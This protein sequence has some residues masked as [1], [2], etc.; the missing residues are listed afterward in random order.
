M[1]RFMRLPLITLLSGVAIAQGVAANDTV[2]V[3]TQSSII[4]SQ[5]IDRQTASAFNALSAGDLQTARQLLAPLVKDYPDYHL[6]QLLY[7]ELHGAKISAGSAMAASTQDLPLIE[8]L[9]EAK[10]RQS[11]QH[12]LSKPVAVAISHPPE[13][14]Q[15]GPGVTHWVQVD[16]KSGSQTVYAVNEQRLQA[17]WQQYIGYGRGG[18]DKR[19]EGD[20]KT[21]LGVYRI[22]GT[23][24]DASL[25]ELYGTGA[26]MLD[27]PN[28][29]DRYAKRTG[30]G[31]WL[32]G[33]PRS[34]HSRSPY[35]S[36]GCVIMGNDYVNALRSHI[37]PSNTLVALSAAGS[38][39]DA[40]VNLDRLRHAFNRWQSTQSK[41]HKL[42]FSMLK[43]E[44]LTITALSAAS[45][46][47]EPQQVATY[48][49]LPGEKS[50]SGNSLK[51][52]FF[53]RSAPGENTWI[54]IADEIGQRGA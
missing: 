38:N 17:L 39:P 37:E 42:D 41:E 10:A 46:G 25:P 54:L 14:L 4:D 21:P 49:Q 30:S 45:I 9:L 40:N 7:A 33:V 47:G 27:Y 16:L 3:T 11:L 19:V 34:S 48:F 23:R 18:Y 20:L 2:P 36:E 6:G 31:I 52:L 15:I 51:A 28:A 44:D 13:L 53:E 1:N 35:S 24:D 12:T 32:H 50:D 8:L 43:F 22:H 5:R 26:L 29:A